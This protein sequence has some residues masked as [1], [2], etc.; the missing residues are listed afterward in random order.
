MTINVTAD[1]VR[2]WN[3]ALHR[4]GET[5]LVESVTEERLAAEVCRLIHDDCVVQV[6]EAYPWPFAIKQTVPSIATGVSREGWEYVY[7]MPDDCVTPLALLAEDERTSQLSKAARTKYQIQSDDNGVRKLILSD[8]EPDDLAALE[9][10]AVIEEIAAYPR[11]FVDA[12]VWLLASE[13]AMAI[14]K[15]MALAGQM[16]QQFYA[17]LHMAAAQAENEN[18]HDEE[19]DTPSIA[20]RA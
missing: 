13:L 15:N 16:R 20:A 8:I 2:L 4:I 10:V 11:A 19:Q 12:L 18:E 6:L 3:R 5:E 17:E 9:Y 14:P 7:V 1:K